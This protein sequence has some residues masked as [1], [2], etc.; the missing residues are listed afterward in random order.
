MRQSENQ[1]YTQDN[2]LISLPLAIIP[3]KMF[4]RLLLLFIIIKDY[5]I[6]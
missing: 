2:N 1:T 3:L 6:I 5:I 4:K